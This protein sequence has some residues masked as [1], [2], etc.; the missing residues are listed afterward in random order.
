[1]TLGRL[2]GDRMV[3]RVGP[4][5]VF[6]AGA[7]L[8]GAGF[9]VG[10]LLGTTTAAVAGL[11]LFGLGLATLLPIT[12]SAAGTTRGLPVPVAVARVSTLG[13]LAQ[14][15]S[16]PTAL[17]VPALAVALTAAAAPAVRLPS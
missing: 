14:H 15:S 1:M 5:R 17:L 12:L 10:L 9:T 6:A 4:G 8:G 3:D 7:L 13:Y 11:A 2:L 16:L